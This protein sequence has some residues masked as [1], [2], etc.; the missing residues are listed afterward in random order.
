M[1]D[2]ARRLLAWFDRHGRHDLP[3]QQEPTPYRVWVSEVMLQ[4][5]QVAT[6]IPYYERFMQRFPDVLCLADA[7]ADDVLAHW[8]GLGYYSRARNLHKAAQVIRD[9]HGGE[10]PQELEAVMA[11]PGIG[12]S[13]AGAILSLACS[14]HQAILDGNVKRVLSRHRAIE[15]WPGKREVEKQLWCWAEQYTPAKRTGDYTQAIMDLGATLCSRSKPRCGDCPVGEDCIA[16]AEGRVAEFP[17]KKPRKALPQKKTRMLL[18]Q[19]SA[20][21]LLLERRPPSGIWGGLWS[22]PESPHEEDI[23][24]R[25]RELGVS[26]EKAEQWP[27]IS[28]TFSHFQLEIEPWLCRVA[29]DGSGQVME[30]DAALWYKTQSFDQL[31]LPAPVKRLLG[32]YAE[33]NE[34]LDS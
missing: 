9:E 4:Q 25:C 15:G 7:P 2:F 18:L 10:F 14:Q 5:T 17:G 21:E 29:E 13:T 1:N 12:R 31:G 26:L 16:A 11:L 27:S 30:P 28:H 24:A 34:E 22:L 6:V 32:W 19:N 23:G 20:G 33:A 3:W 8:S